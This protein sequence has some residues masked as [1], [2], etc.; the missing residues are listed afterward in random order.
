MKV[1]IP[2][3]ALRPFLIVA[4]A[5]GLLSGA[6]ALEKVDQQELVGPSETGVSVQ[7]T[8]LPDV[9]NADGVSTVLVELQV[10]A[11]SG[12]ALSGLAVLFH[13]D[14]APGDGQM[15]QDPGFTY[16]GPVQEGIVMATD[17][18]GRARVIYTAGTAAGTTATISVRPYGID[19]IRFFT[20]TVDIL[21]R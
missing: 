21:Q 3:G 6:C 17:G 20:R 13:L 15:L 19:G 7:L 2:D 18:N 4:V 16:V 8:A 12:E 9:V 10:R 11:N 5:G 14:S 1:R